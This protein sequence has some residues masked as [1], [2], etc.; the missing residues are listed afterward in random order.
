MTIR[1]PKGTSRSADWVRN[2]VSVWAPLA[3]KYMSSPDSTGYSTTPP[4]STPLSVMPPC[5]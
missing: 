1:I 2:S 3:P 4:K 5:M